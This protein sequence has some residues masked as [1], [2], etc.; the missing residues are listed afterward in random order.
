MV[1]IQESQK[2]KNRDGARASACG[3]PM[4]IADSRVTLRGSLIEAA[5]RGEPT[6]INKRGREARTSVAAAVRN[7]RRGDE[8]SEHGPRRRRGV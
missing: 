2:K 1:Q 5:Y 4:R 6:A 8:Q 3:T 7:A